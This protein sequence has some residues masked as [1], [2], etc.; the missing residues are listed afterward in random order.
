MLNSILCIQNPSVTHLS[1]RGPP[2]K[3]SPTDAFLSSL[4]FFLILFKIYQLDFSKTIRSN[5]IFVM[6]W[7]LYTKHVFQ[8][9]MEYHGL[10]FGSNKLFL[11]ET[12]RRL[13]EFFFLS[14]LHAKIFSK[15]K[16]NISPILKYCQ[17]KSIFLM[18]LIKESKY[19]THLNDFISVIHL[20]SFALTLQLIHCLI[21][22]NIERCHFYI[23]SPISEFT[24]VSM[25]NALGLTRGRSRPEPTWSFASHEV[26]F[27]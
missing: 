23:S 10:N 11:M 27:N 9:K 3:P 7:L 2:S 5:L 24:L 20:I 8:E 6:C 22:F 4:S 21:I 14:L 25:M 16:S 26:Q 13:N 18:P 17:F 19:L 15:L 12:H 1:K